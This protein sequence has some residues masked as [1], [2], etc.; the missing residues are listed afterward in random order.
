LPLIRLLV[1]VGEEVKEIKN[2]FTFT[3]TALKMGVGV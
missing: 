3:E 2:P 1:E